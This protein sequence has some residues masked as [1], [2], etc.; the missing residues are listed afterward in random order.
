MK[1]L[2]KVLSL[3]L[4]L[5]MLLGMMIMPQASAAGTM[6]YADLVDKDDITNLAEVALLVDLE[7]IEGKT[8]S[9]YD[10]TGIVDRAT[11]AKLVTLLHFGSVDPNQFLGTTSDL[12]DIKGNWAEGY[13]LYCYTQG[14]IAG[15]GMGKFFPSNE[16]TVAEAA[17]M[18]LVTLGYDANKA[19]LVGADWAVNTISTATSAT[20]LSGVGMR[21]S[22]KLDRDTLALMMYNT[23]FS[24]QVAYNSLFGNDP[25]SKNNTLGLATYGLVK[26]T[27]L[28]EKATD[29][30]VT[31]I[32]NT[33]ESTPEVLT[34]AA[35]P[36][37]AINNFKLGGQQAFIGQYATGYI[38]VR[39]TMTNA[40]SG[41]N[42]AATVTPTNTIIKV[43]SSELT[44]ADTNVFVSTDGTNLHKLFNGSTAVSKLDYSGTTAAPVL[45]T[46]FY[47]NDALLTIGTTGDL[48]LDDLVPANLEDFY[49]TIRVLGYTGSSARAAAILNAI[50]GKGNIVQISDTNN[51]GFADVVY[52]TD[53]TAVK[54]TRV[55]K[56]EITFNVALG[57]NG[58]P[59]TT[60][61][62]L[63]NVVGA[64]DLKVDDYAYGYVTTGEKLL[65]N[66]PTSEDVKIASETSS[67]I[68]A[69][70]NTYSFSYR[71]LSGVNH[72]DIVPDNEVTL[73][74][75]ANGYIIAADL[76]EGANNFAM[77]LLVDG[78]T[79]VVRQVKLLL[80]D[81]T[82]IVGTIDKLVNEAGATIT[83]LA[84][85]NVVK[86]AVNDNS[87]LKVTHVVTG[88]TPIAADATISTNQVS[89][90]GAY[91]TASDSTIFADGG[92]KTSYT[93]Y[94][95]IPKFVIDNSVK[96]EFGAVYTKP[97]DS[98]A[99]YVFISDS[100]TTMGADAL[101]VVFA[102]SGSAANVETF[103]KY[104]SMNVITAEGVVRKDFDRTT[105]ALSSMAAGNIYVAA[106]SAVVD[107]VTVIAS[108]DTA[109][110]NP[111][112]HLTNT[113]AEGKLLG[114]VAG[115]DF[116]AA[117]GTLTMA[118][119]GVFTIKDTTV[120]TGT[121]RIDDTTMVVEIA[122]DGKA[123]DVG[124]GIN[125]STYMNEKTR[126]LTV[127][128]NVP[129]ATTT[130]PTAKIIVIHNAD[131]PR[132]VGA[133]TA[134]APVTI[135]ADATV[136][137]KLS[138]LDTAAVPVLAAASDVTVVGSAGVTVT[139]VTAT[140]NA[141]EFTAK[142]AVA[143]GTAAG[144]TVTVTYEGATVTIVVGA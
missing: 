97:G 81:G 52:I 10:P 28:V 24:N 129:S 62:K 99:S 31:F 50:A 138:T 59:A 92:S 68:R 122:A 105:A 2:K 5:V 61:W 98:T 142:I 78:G 82:T 36:A 136:T 64:E 49:K 90:G 39:T 7:I 119:A 95:A 33:V 110:T 84:P 101:F 11:M 125:L 83:S 112:S 73:F 6:T 72:K 76:I 111:W 91:G 94:K 14:I 40:G 87:T 79:S 43:Y 137:F 42:L 25:I 89:I 63:E 116:K 46:A 80:T 4:A 85:G 71:S 121:Y 124:Y 30:D 17:K 127:I 1:N 13:I 29:K 108:V 23:L 77:V 12:T 141:G 19:G 74:L 67:A 9:V 44:L 115:G 118:D 104:Y 65:L 131:Q 22:D 60:K 96:G 134:G 130:T 69:D 41:F 120:T 8:G 143:T 117:H 103:P 128:T 55:T 54:V 3:S 139:D 21:A 140:A 66:T 100:A 53:Y 16:V 132:L 107:G 123:T 48:T 47:Y 113:P 34:N 133:A 144:A 20:I 37:Q 15:D 86:Y 126:N 56:D 109:K 57:G 58:V 135:G 51:D 114:G 38:Q 35:P 18:L 88:V 93:G 26:I 27:G 75:D 32:T 102:T 45:D 106:S 70:G